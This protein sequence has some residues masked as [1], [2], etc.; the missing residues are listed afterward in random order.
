MF[1]DI[2]AIIIL[3]M[4]IFKGY[5]RGLIVSILS[6]FAIIIG[7]AAAMK[8]SVTVAAWLQNNTNVGTQWL[9]FLSFIII[10]IFVILLVRWIANLAQAAIEVVLLGWLNKLGG[11]I[12]Y[13]LLY[14][15]VYSV[16]LFYATQMGLLK[17]ETIQ[18]SQTYAIIEPWGPQVINAL[19]YILPFFK[20]MFKDL[21]EFFGGIAGNTA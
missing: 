18:A 14:M 3:A 10:M 8:L 5:S 17:E 12:L 15:M 1:I 20:D 7:L 21:Q 4:A 9:P 16:L 11:I 13:M 19:G 6:F 2:I